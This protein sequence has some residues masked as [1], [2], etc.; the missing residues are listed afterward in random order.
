MTMEVAPK[1]NGT[2]AISRSAACSTHLPDVAVVLVYVLHG[3]LNR[4]LLDPGGG[5]VGKN[6]RRNELWRAKINFPLTS[7]GIQI[8]EAQF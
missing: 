6:T 1:P 3:G 2:T 8:F 7:Q 5:G 4:H